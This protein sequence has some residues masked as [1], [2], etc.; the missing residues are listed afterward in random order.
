MDMSCEE[1]DVMVGD[2]SGRSGMAYLRELRETG[3]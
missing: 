2:L 1:P 3:S